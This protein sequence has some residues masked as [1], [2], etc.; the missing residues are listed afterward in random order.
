MNPVTALRTSSKNP[1]AR[2]P[3]MEAIFLGNM[4]LMHLATL[5]EVL[6]GSWG[7]VGSQAL[8]LT[9]GHTTT[10]P[11]SPVSRR[12]PGRMGRTGF[13]RQSPSLAWQSRKIVDLLPDYTSSSGNRRGSTLLI[14][15]SFL[16]YLC[17]SSFL[18][19]TDGVEKCGWGKSQYV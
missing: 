18:L 5:S 7:I 12:P 3:H 6:G 19:R 13:G 17:H 15:W 16:W 8:G 10:P 9:G 11:W 14:F 4:S 1:C 2:I